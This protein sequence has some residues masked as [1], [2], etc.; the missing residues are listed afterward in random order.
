MIARGSSTSRELDW[1]ILFAFITGSNSLEPL[2]E[3]LLAQI[4]M[5]LNSRVFGRNRTGELR[6]THV[7]GAVLVST[8]LKWQINPSRSMRTHFWTYTNVQIYTSAGIESRTCGYPIFL[9]GAKL[10]FTELKWR[11]NYMH[12]QDHLDQIARYALGFL[13]SHPCAS[14][15]AHTHT[16]TPRVAHTCMWHT[17]THTHTHMH[18]HAHK[19]I[20]THTQHT[21]TRTH[22]LTGPSRPECATRPWLFNISKPRILPAPHRTPCTSPEC[23]QR[24]PIGNTKCTWESDAFECDRR[25]VCSRRCW[26]SCNRR[27]WGGGPNSI[28]EAEPTNHLIKYQ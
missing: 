1:L 17:H 24:N 25:H 6:I 22:A 10:L 2:L 9:L 18:T 12:A 16:H 28:K 23:S 3:G 15:R 14:A 7:L 27:G 26:R 21:H 5:D 8:E 11:M 19:Y 20:H 13:A 4:H